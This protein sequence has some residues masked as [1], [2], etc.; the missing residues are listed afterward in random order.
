MG[1]VAVSPGFDYRRGLPPVQNA[2]RHDSTKVIDLM[3]FQQHPR[4][5]TLFGS[6]SIGRVELSNRVALAPMTRVSATSD[7]VPTDRIGAYYRVFA[8]GGF[9]LLITEGLYID[10]QASQGYLFQPG[11]ANPVQAAAWKR[12]VE[13]VH[14]SGSK[15]FA[16]L[17]HAGSQSQGNPHLN[18]TWGPSA[19]RPRGEQ[20]GMYR[21]A[22]PFQIP[23]AMTTEHIGQV[24]D[25][26]AWFRS[27]ALCAPALERGEKVEATLPIRNINRVVGTITGSEVT[28]RYG[29]Q[30]LPDD[31]IRLNFRG[32]A[33]QS[34]GAF[35]P[36]GMTLTLE[37][38]S[39]DYVGK[40][41]SGGKI[42]VFPPREATFVAEENV[43]IGNV[44]FYGATAGE[45]YI[46]GV[47]GERFCVRNSGVHAVVE[48]VGDHGCEYMT[49]GRVV[50]LGTTGRNFAAGMSGGVAYVMDEAGD[51]ARRCNKEMVNLGKVEDPEEV[52]LVQAMI[53]R[54]AQYT[55]SKRAQEVLGTWSQWLPY[56]VRVMPKDYERVL[57]AQREMR[58]AGLS[59]E[60][61]EMAAFEQN[62]KSAARLGG[63]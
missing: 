21:G 24:D 50:V 16:Q 6:T 62:S 44:A 12:V 38:D 27:C 53:A 36:P 30:G 28:R 51:F 52:K 17:M 14:A 25:V 55:G 31:T 37:G 33:G 11:I 58:A 57:A 49:G 46:R 20:L 1:R 60:E 32:S 59:P 63:K 7:G 8:D 2:T 42:V 35:V 56:F 45:G 10:D 26:C 47:A 15:F 4:Y 22:G 61:A 23:E 40:G 43:I 9:G 48:G 41:L 54:H 19:V 3:S 13:G 29:P 39:N 5:E 18:T 34:F